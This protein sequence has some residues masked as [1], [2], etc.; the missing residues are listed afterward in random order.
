MAIMKITITDRAGEM[1]NIDMMYESIAAAR[2][3]RDQMLPLINW[4]MRE[5]AIL[6]YRIVIE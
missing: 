4:L 5:S 6:F 3:A 1:H 2:A